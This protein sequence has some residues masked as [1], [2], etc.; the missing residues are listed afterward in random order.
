MHVALRSLALTLLPSKQGQW[1]VL[2]E[3]GTRL[4]GVTI[5]NVL[6]YL[7]RFEDGC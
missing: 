5:D 1:H 4:T 7:A 6:Y 3:R 2:H